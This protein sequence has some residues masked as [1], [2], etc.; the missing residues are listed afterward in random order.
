MSYD[1]FGNVESQSKTELGVT[2]DTSYTYDAAD[3]VATL[4][5][6]SGRVIT[7]QRDS[8]GRVSSVQSSDVTNALISNRTYRADGNVTGQTFGS[9]LDETRS[10]DNQGRLTQQVLGSIK[11]IDY[12]Y[13]ANG[14]LITLDKTPTTTTQNWGYDYDALD[15]LIDDLKGDT[16]DNI[17][18]YTYQYDGNGNREAEN[19]LLLYYD[20]NTNRLN[21]SNGVNLTYDGAGN[22]LT[23]TGGHAFAYNLAGRLSEFSVNGT[24][25]AS[26]TYNAQGQRT[27][28]VQGSTTTL[29]HYDLSGLLIAEQIVGNTETLDT[30]WVDGE[31]IAQVSNADETVNANPQPDPIPDPGPYV[32]PTAAQIATAKKILPIIYALLLDDDGIPPPPPPAPDPDDKVTF[33]HA[34]HLNTPRLATDNGETIVWRW[35]GK[36][37]GDSTPNTDPD[38]DGNTTTIN[39]RFLGQYADNESGLYYN[40]NR[41]YDPTLG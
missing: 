40:W 21:Q 17:D 37:F 4:T 35:E 12:S 30:V 32:P 15:R 25:S 23:G 19:A 9:G 14:N 36:A 22:L 5:Y 27:R 39:L 16:Q 26:Y 6:P 41:Y 8:I 20:A 38:G 18:D 11:T 1:G 29:Y 33:I 2:Y 10:Y 28:K 24:L 7:T 13:D 34:D 3:R 31:P